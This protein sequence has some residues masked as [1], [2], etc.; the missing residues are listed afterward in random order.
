MSILLDNNAKEFGF[1]IYNT[2]K[3]IKICVRSFGYGL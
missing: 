3:S 1:G 2:G